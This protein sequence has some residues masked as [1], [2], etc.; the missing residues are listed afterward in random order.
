MRILIV[1]AVALIAAVFAPVWARDVSHAQKTQ[2]REIYRT[3]VEMDTS[4]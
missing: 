1:A 2:L 4:V 3:I